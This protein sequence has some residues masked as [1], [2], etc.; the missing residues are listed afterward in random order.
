MMLLQTKRL[1]CTCMQFK[2]RDTQ[3]TSGHPNTD[4]P[5]LA[6]R[7]HLITTYMLFRYIYNDSNTS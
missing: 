4:Q 3:S 6:N 7:A 1:L 2:E 5:S